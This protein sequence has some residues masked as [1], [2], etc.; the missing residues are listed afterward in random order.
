MKCSMSG[1]L[2]LYTKD[3]IADSSIAQINEKYLGNDDLNT[4]A[5]P[6]LR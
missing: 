2:F 5:F 4:L 6:L 1:C 3:N